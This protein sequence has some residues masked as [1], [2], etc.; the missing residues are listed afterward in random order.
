MNG[1]M[2]H[3]GGETINR[4]EISNLP[5]PEA[6]KSHV[7]IPHDRLISSVERAIASSPYEIVNEGHGVSHEGQRYFGVLELHAEIMHADYSLTVGIRNSHDKM[8]PAGITAGSKVFVCDNLCFSGEVTTFRRHTRYILRDLDNRIM[9]TMGRL[10]EAERHQSQRIDAY[11]ITDMSDRDVHDFLIRSV[12]S[13]VIPASKIPKVLTEWREPSHEEFTED[14]NAWRLMNAYTEVF[15]EV[16]PQ[17]LTTR[18][19]TLHGMLDMV[20]GIASN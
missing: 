8:F 9:Q 7:P 18:G 11:R 10:G 2:I 1:L 6:T 5:V 14:R 17:T 19:M 12:D 20:S 13:Q 4:A 3:A 15:K 16:N